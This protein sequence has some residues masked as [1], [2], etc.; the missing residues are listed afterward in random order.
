MQEEVEISE[1][2]Q[3]VDFVTSDTIRNN[4]TKDLLISDVSCAKVC[5]LK[6]FN[7]FATVGRH[8]GLSNVYIKLNLFQ[9][10]KQ[11]QNKELQNTPT[12]FS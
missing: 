4:G 10:R 8:L 12:R 9:R 2:V 3:S 1:F 7:D 6:A 11:G 5:N